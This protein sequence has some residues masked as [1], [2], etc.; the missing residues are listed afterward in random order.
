MPAALVVGPRDVGRLVA[1]L[2]DTPVL[3][4]TGGPGVG[5]STT[6]DAL[7]ALLALRSD[8]PRLFRTA[9]DD[10]TRRRPVRPRRRAGRPRPRVPPARRPG[11]TRRGPGGA[12]VRRRPGRP[13]SPTTCT[14]PIPIRSPCSPGSP[15]PSC[16]SRCCSPPVRCR[17]GNSSSRWPRARCGR[18]GGRRAR[19]RRA[20]RPGRGPLR[21]AAGARPAGAAGP[22]RRQPVPRQGVA[23]ASSTGAGGWPSTA[24]RSEVH[25]SAVDGVPDSVRSAA[26]AQLAVVT[27]APGS[28]CRSSRSG[29]VRWA[30]RGSPRPAARL[31]SRCW[32]RSRRRWPRV[33]RGG[34]PTASCWSSATTC[35]G[36]SSTPISTRP[37]AVCCTTPAPGCC[38]PR[39]GRVP[40][41]CT[42][43]RARS[44]PRG[45]STSCATTWARPPRR[46]P[47]CWPRCGRARPSRPTPSPSPGRRRSRPRA[48][49]GRPNGWPASGSPSPPTPRRRPPSPASCCTSS[50]TPRTW[51]VCWPSSTA[52]SRCRSPPRSGRAW[53]GCGSSSARWRAGVGP[54]RARTC[55]RRGGAHRLRAV[56]QPGRPAVGAGGSGRRNHRV[57]GLHLAVADP[58]VGPDLA[59]DLRRVRRGPRRGPA[60][61]ARD[62]AARAAARPDVAQP[63]P[64]LPHRG[65]RLPG[66]PVG[67]RARRSRS[68]PGGRVRVRH[69]LDLP[70]GGHRRPHPGAAR[71]AGCGRRRTWRTGRSGACPSSSG[72]RWSPS[73]RCC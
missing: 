37:Y 71:P 38:A 51:R 59:R 25:D 33:S 36:R 10:T 62:P 55:H 5:K 22:H 68:G 23:R 31:P 43:K 65:H 6:L 19:R 52:P 50:R 73:G 18:R 34:R 30:S 21:R 58:A 56:P 63:R 1:L 44:T 16:R 13:A 69:G 54:T 14:R 29:V 8:A 53:T 60:A 41:C 3:L 4:L 15:R 42:T 2:D 11:R 9:A 40:R 39:A 12:A 45:R 70:R 7:A 27:P 49:R 26:R 46:R 17:C 24:A 61:L 20:G 57:T 32:V 47:T 35:T 64:P 72:C 66:R 67:R 28:C 48:T